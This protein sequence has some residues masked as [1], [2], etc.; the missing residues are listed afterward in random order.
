MTSFFSSLFHYFR[1]AIRALFFI[2]FLLIALELAQ[3][4]H[5]LRFD[6]KVRSELV[7]FELESTSSAADG[8]EVE[9]GVKSY[10]RDNYKQWLASYDELSRW[11]KPFWLAKLPSGYINNFI[12]TEFYPG[13]P[14]TL[15]AVVYGGYGIFFDW[16][17]WH[18]LG[19][20]FSLLFRP[21]RRKKQQKPEKIPQKMTIDTSSTET[22]S[23]EQDC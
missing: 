3:L 4:E 1:L 2:L 9:R 21:F 13:L 22:S 17:L 8:S 16:I 23:N 15:E 20:F 6:F 14:L 7:Q 11:L 5:L 10:T 19:S 18:L 12:K